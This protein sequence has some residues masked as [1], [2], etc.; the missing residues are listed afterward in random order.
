MFFKLIYYNHRAS[1]NNMSIILFLN[2][3][4]G[5]DHKNGTEGVNF[6]ICRSKVKLSGKRTVVGQ[7]SGKRSTDGA[8]HL[9]E[10][11]SG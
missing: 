7:N 10:N 8:T 5:R 2:E 1:V 4:Y 3:D 6:K 11:L 9:L